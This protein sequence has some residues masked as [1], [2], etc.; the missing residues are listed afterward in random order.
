MDRPNQW[1]FV[2]SYIHQ[3]SINNNLMKF[4]HFK[5]FYNYLITGLDIIICYLRY[6]QTLI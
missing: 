4:S 5:G 2:Q 1:K 3:M 6:A